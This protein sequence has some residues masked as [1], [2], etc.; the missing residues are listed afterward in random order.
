MSAFLQYVGTFFMGA[1]V[2][3]FLLFSLMASKD[4]DS[5]ALETLLI[6]CLTAIP[7]TLAVMAF[8]GASQLS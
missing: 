8:M 6:L 4:P 2:V 5:G 3:V 7:G 1:A